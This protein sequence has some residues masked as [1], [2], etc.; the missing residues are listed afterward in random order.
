MTIT[1]YN[2]SGEPNRINKT[3]T[4]GTQMTGTMRNPSEVVTPTVLISADPI[5]CNYA[6]ISELHRYY[7]ITD[8]RIVRNGLYEIQLKSDPLKSFAADI[9]ELPAYCM[10]TDRYGE[11]GSSPYIIDQYAPVAAYDKIV[12]YDL[13]ELFIGANKILVTAG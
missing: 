7:W 11:Y 4:G 2:Y 1:I 10:R 12:T 9:M 6:Y 3:L 5:G 13:G 8:T